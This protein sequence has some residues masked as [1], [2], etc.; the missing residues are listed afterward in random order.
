[1]S[2]VKAAERGTTNRS[3]LE[4]D[5]SFVKYFQLHALPPTGF[6]GAVCATATC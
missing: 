1:M 4:R 5:A 3:E 2:R 6:F